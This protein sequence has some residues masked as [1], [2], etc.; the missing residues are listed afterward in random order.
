MRPKVLNRYIF[1]E[2]AVPFSLSIF[3][4]T[5]T[6]LLSKVM[7]LI[8]LAVVQGVG[9]AYLLQF[10]LSV[11]P[12]FLIYTIPISFLIAVLAAFGRLS[13]DSELTAMK[14]SGM[15][16]FTLMKP[17]AFAASIAVALTVV[18]TIILFPWG[19]N[20][21]K[22]LLFEASRN[23]LASSIE[24]KTFYDRFAGFTLYVD[25]VSQDTG[26]MEGI[27]LAQESK[28][29]AN[30]FFAGKGALAVSSDDAAIYFKLFD[31]TIHRQG[32]GKGEYN[33]VDFSVYT[34]DLGSIGDG[35]SSGRS[36][37]ELYAGELMAKAKAAGAKGENA[38][39]Y[40]IDLHKRFALPASVIVFALLGVPLG[41]QKARQ[42]RSAGF[43]VALGVTLAYYVASTAL[44]ALGE[45]GR[46]NP[47]L[48][49][50]GSDIIFAC[51]GVY[52]FYQAARDRSAF[53]SIAGLAV[54]LKSG[55]GK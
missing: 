53:A 10:V 41:I 54:R 1:L 14:A 26:E 20:N 35:R 16:L 3:I 45:N 52:V 6:A 4:L 25:R 9:A 8:E 50:W 48:A 19:N 5:A 32:A 21:I 49:V 47:Y 7:K 44:E 15:S 13:S 23:A 30:I 2:I 39:P 36:N 18:A 17:V 34:L 42:A 22:K 55:K 51:I 43:S 24:E 28:G 27:F 40:L 12:S 37:R 11:M 46:L 33:I 31:G 29:S 38:A